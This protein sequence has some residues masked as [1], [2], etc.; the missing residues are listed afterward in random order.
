MVA[1]FSE[2]MAE[3]AWLYRRLFWETGLIGQVL[4]L[5]A[6]AAGYRGTGIGC[7]FDDSVHELLG[8][9]DEQFQSLYHFTIG[10]PLEDKRI[11]TLPAYEHLDIL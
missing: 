2:T 8:F 1:E 5:E 4:Y 3:A 9:K 6:E 11:E 7:Y 10:K